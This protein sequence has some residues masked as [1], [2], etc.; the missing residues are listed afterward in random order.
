MCV[1]IRLHPIHIY[2]AVQHVVTPTVI[3]IFFHDS[4]T[5]CPSHHI[6]LNLLGVCII[7]S[8]SQCPHCHVIPSNKLPASSFHGLVVMS[9]TTPTFIWRAKQEDRG[10]AAHSFSL[11]KHTVWHC[12]LCASWFT[13]TGSCRVFSSIIFFQTWA[14]IAIS[15]FPP[16]NLRV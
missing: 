16:L 10:S 15:F 8:V 5:E 9:L 4:W 7:E 12:C 11:K 1:Y 6:V 13:V 2:K 14:L 3:K